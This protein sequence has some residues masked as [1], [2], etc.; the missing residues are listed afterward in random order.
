MPPDWAGT[1]TVRVL[2]VVPPPQ[3]MVQVVQV[4]HAV[5]LHSTSQDARLHDSDSE[6]AGQSVPPPDRGVMMYLARIRTAPPQEFWHGCHTAQSDTTQSS[7]GVPG[8]HVKVLHGC[9]SANTGHA[10]PPWVAPASTVLARVETPVS[11]PTVHAP[12]AAHWETRQS[13]AHCCTLHEV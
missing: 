6:S 4:D 10:A 13:L 12:Q 5:T 8:G 3:L 7:L 11:Q 2:L 9:V 1:S